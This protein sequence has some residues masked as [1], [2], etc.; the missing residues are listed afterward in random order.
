MAKEEHYTGSQTFTL[1]VDESANLIF[2]EK[3]KKSRANVGFLMI[4]YAIVIY[5]I[6]IHSDLVGFIVTLLGGIS[7]AAFLAALVPFRVV[8]ETDKIILY[9]RSLFGIKFKREVQKSQIQSI[10][11]SPISN[12][13][14]GKVDYSRVRILT[15]TSS[16]ITLYND[17]RPSFEVAKLDSARLAARFAEKIGTTVSEDPKPW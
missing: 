5:R 10:Q 3:K 12:K 16:T 9:R 8:V 11:T 6:W 13:L 14:F 2:Q 17:S 4:A 15:T 1:S 7:L